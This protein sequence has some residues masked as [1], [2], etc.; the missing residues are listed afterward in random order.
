[1]SFFH[2]NKK[3][4]IES[5]IIQ[6]LTGKK[7]HNI[8]WFNCNLILT[9]L[10]FSI[11]L[12]L[13][14]N[15]F[16]IIQLLGIFGY[17]YYNLHSDYHLFNE[18]ITEINTLIQDFSK[19]LFFGAIGISVPYIIDINSLKKK[20]KRAIFF[21]LVFLYI[22]RDYGKIIKILYYLKNILFGIGAVS[23]FILFLMLPLDNI[24]N[25]KI[26]QLIIVIT[27]YT[28]G[29]YYLHTKIQEEST[30]K[31]TKLKKYHNK[32]NN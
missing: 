17:F 18:Y 15:N 5:L 31:K 11:I 24:K 16:F 22:I 6:F 13:K 12:L 28:G 26:N 7:I 23:L 9:Y 30:I 1:M 10:L 8:F 27:N 2:K 4:T 19:V 20:R 25:K 3:I 32:Y 29:V 14:Y 21:S